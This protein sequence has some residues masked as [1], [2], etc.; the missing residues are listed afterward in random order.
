MGLAAD[1]QYRHHRPNPFQRVMQA[2][3]SSK[4]GAWLFSK[5]LR[6]LDRALL[7]VTKGRATVPQLLAGLPVVTVTTTGRK[8]G[9]ARTTPLI[10]IPI[11][12]TLALL[13]TNFGQQHT[14]AWVYNLEADPHL[15]IVHDRITQAAVARPASEAERAEVMANSAGVYGGYL[16]YQ[17]RITGRDVRIFVL[18]PA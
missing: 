18:D 5:T 13:G 3:A 2:F 4:P 17:Q 15:T 6:H 16:K 9:Q 14:P 11:G 8:S 10:S 12:D 1:L 7:R